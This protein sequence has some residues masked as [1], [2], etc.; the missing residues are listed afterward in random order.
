M[1]YLDNSLNSG[2]S[3]HCGKIYGALEPG[4]QRGAQQGKTQALPKVKLMC[5]SPNSHLPAGWIG[6]FLM[7]R[8]FLIVKLALESMSD[9]SVQE[10]R[11]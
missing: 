4:K 2:I 5:G 7:N 9:I 6:D 11:D 8:N 10:T 1:T 3:F